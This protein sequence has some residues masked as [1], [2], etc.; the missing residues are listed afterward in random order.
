MD[1]VVEIDD[2]EKYA[3]EVKIRITDAASRQGRI[4]EEIQFPADCAH[5]GFIPRLLVFDPT[6]CATLRELIAAFKRNDGNCYLGEAAYT[7]V[8]EL[9]GEAN[10]LFL[11][12]YVA[13]PLRVVEQT[14]PDSGEGRA[15]ADL[16]LSAASGHIVVT[17]TGHPPYVIRRQVDPTSAAGPQDEQ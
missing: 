12:R 5:S 14:I 13:K 2:N 9:A 4:A 10:A 3:Y 1:A 16:Q 6:D 11:E 7:H 15:L 8:R 17:V